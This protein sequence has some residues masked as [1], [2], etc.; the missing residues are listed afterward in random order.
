MRTL[1]ER[2]N[3]SPVLTLG[4]GE[5]IYTAATCRGAHPA[6][7]ERL[8]AIEERVRYDDL[9]EQSALFAIVECLPL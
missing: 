9:G 7:N 8:V 5:S 2:E 6:R 4:L 1:G 3:G